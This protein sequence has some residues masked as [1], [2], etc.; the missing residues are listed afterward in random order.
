LA[1]FGDQL[2]HYHRTEKILPVYVLGLPARGDDMDVR[3]GAARS[4]KPFRAYFHGGD[5]KPCIAIRLQVTNQKISDSALEIRP[6]T[7]NR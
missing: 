7:R 1:R 6:F 3:I 2:I 5:H 4:G